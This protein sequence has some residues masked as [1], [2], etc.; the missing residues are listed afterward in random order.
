ML[1]KNENKVI[2]FANNFMLNEFWKGEDFDMPDALIKAAQVI[3]NWH[4]GRVTVTSTLR[5]KDTFGQHRYGKAIDL[6]ATKKEAKLAFI[7]LFYFET[8]SWI[9]GNGSTLIDSLRKVGITGMGP[10]NTCVHLDCRN[11]N[12]CNRM[13]QYGKYIAFIYR[14]HIDEFGNL[15]IDENRAI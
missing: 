9:N 12:K 5:K 3:R 6:V 15:I 1:I 2:F 8:M 7:D 13:D 10:E 11:T 4:N 14:Q